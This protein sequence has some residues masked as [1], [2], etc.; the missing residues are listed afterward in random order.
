MMNQKKRDERP[1][2][3][4][5][6][7]RLI[8]DVLGAALGVLVSFLAMVIVVLVIAGIILIG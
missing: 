2:L 1:V 4:G 5:G 7:G 8:H 3:L 6:Q